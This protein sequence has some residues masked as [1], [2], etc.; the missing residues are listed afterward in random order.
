MNKYAIIFDN[1]YSKKLPCLRGS[2]PTHF[3]SD[4][5]AHQGT[6]FKY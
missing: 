5:L 1:D 6:H 3:C 4:L 2:S